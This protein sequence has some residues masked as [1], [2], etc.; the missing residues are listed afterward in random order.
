MFEKIKK[1]IKR[2]VDYRIV[3]EYLDY[4]EKTGRYV[5]KFKRKY[6]VKLNKR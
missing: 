5:R 1:L 4:D 6:Y 3:G 2:Y